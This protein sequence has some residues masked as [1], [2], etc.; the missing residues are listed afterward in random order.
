MIDLNN[1][2][3]ST[4][5]SVVSGLRNEKNNLEIQLRDINLEYSRNSSDLRSIPQ[6]ERAFSDL[7]RQQNIK[8][9]LFLYLLQ[10]KEERYMNMTTVEPNSR[11]IDNIQV[12]G[13]AWPNN[14]LILL[15]A[16]FMGL[17]LPLV[18]I[19]INH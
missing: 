18:G 4:F 16:L 14:M 1:Q 2:L 17:V 5:I 9:D 11:I 6:Q 12:M 15:I 7:K 13:T 10:K 19:K 8:E 3:E